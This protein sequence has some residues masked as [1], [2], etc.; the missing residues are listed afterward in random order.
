MTCPEDALVD[1]RL[2]LI[3]KVVL[4]RRVTGLPRSYRAYTA[5]LGF[6]ERFAPWSVDTYTFGSALDDDARARRAAVGEAAE[7]YCGN[8]VP[9]DLL[10]GSYDHLARA[11]APVVD[12]LAFALYS[13]RQYATPGFPF[14]PMT[15]DREI[16]WVTG[17]DLGSGQ[18]VLLPASLVY[19]NY[20]RGA[21]AREPV[22]NSPL[23]AGIAAGETDAQAELFALQE[24]LER[25][26]T[27]IWWLS[28]SAAVGIDIA[29]HPAISAVFDPR[30]VPDLAVS[31]LHIRSSFE[32]PVIGV[33]VEDTARSLVAFGSACR[34]SPIEATSKALTEVFD[35][36]SLS[37]AMLDPDGLL[38]QATSRG[39]PHYRPFR[40]DRAYLD[41]FRPDWRDVND[42]PAHAQLHLD[43]RMRGP[44]LERM[45]APHQRTALEDLSS[46]TAPHGLASYVEHIESAG[47]KA[48]AVDLTTADIAT[49][50]LR[51]SRVL[52]PGLYCN[53]PAAFPLLGGDRL[54]TEPVLHGWTDTPV[55]EETLVRHPLPHT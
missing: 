26:A 53:A 44:V 34:S 12:P 6:T 20:F 39:D 1:S 17:R 21:H 19:L 35:V 7:R 28:G 22:T 13:A 16:S 5:F 2:G 41:D 38:A 42:L 3:R 40:A 4:N 46:F 10:S 18:G 50:G 11:G 36:L 52:V 23:Y 43:P 29:H 8:V 24:V 54:Y 55:T 31:F 49:A 33:F 9:S 15:R 14:A 27:A 25:D 30:E 51:V 48:Y 37:V 32:V 45:R 47:L